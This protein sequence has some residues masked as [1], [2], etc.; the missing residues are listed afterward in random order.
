[1]FLALVGCQVTQKGVERKKNAI[2]LN[3]GENLQTLDPRKARDLYSMNVIRMFFEGLTRT[4]KEQKVELALAQ[5]VDISEDGLQYR[6]RLRKSHWSNAD[7]VTSLDF[8]ESWKTILDPN[9]PTDIAYYLYVIKGARKA[10]LGEIPMQEV[11]IQTPDAQTLIVDLETPIPYFLELLSLPPFFPVNH[12]L[13]QSNPDWAFQS[14]SY[15]GNGPFFMKEW[16]A[17]EKIIARKNMKYWQ[18]DQVALENLELLMVNAD[19]ELLMF[20]EGKLDWAGSPLSSIPFNAIGEL[21]E[22]RLLHIE[23]YSAT[24][25]F[26]INTDE[27]FAA[28]TNPLHSPLLR[29]ALALAI[30]RKEIVEHVLQAGQIPARG[31]VPPELGLAERG[32]FQDDNENRAK[33]YFREALLE[34]S[35]N[36]SDL[37]GMKLTYYSSDRNGGVAQ[38]VQRQ[39]E[40]VLGLHVEL[41]AV[42]PKVFF[43]KTSHKEYQIAIRSWT[44][45]FKD[46]INFLEIFKYKDTGTNNTGWENA[47]YIDLLD[48]SA[49]CKDQLERR[50]ILREA[51]LILMEQMPIIPIY[52]YTLNF[53][54][55]EGLEGVVLS[56]LGQVDFRWAHFEDASC[57]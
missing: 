11:G 57:L 55:K 12:R 47:K 56:P 45:D 39:W 49:L 10:K 42:E 41:E 53:L 4:S 52:H 50:S 9:F 31:F 21:K 29:K 24:Y 16:K 48:Q 19:A 17:S 51:E 13:V 20:E 26:M 15:V 37:Q 33:E 25:F 14:A 30:H 23:P 8:A 34:L 28:K 46:P 18:A 6:F 40:R 7:A 54:C 1:M 38:A 36:E 3:I 43:E 44:A 32:Y 27:K 2:S 35:L 5:S 22:K